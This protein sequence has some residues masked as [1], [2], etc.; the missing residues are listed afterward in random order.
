MFLHYGG[1][2]MFS[3]VYSAAI[4]GMES[5]KVAVEAD[6]ADGLPVFTMVGFLAS[7]TREASERVRSALRNSGL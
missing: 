1:S 7:E 5:R 6:V 2:L 4:D 3:T